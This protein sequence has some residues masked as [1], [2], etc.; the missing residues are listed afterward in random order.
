M[1]IFEREAF[2]R[3]KRERLEHPQIGVG[4]GLLDR[5]VLARNDEIEQSEPFRPQRRF[6]EFDDI[7]PRRGG[8]DREPEAAGARSADQPLDAGAKRTLARPDDFGVMGV[9]AHMKRGDVR[10]GKLGR[11]D[12]AHVG[13]AAH[14]L[15]AAGD[16]VELAVEV[17]VPRPVEAR[18]DEGGVERG[19]VALLRLGQGSVDVENER[20]DHIVPL[21][22]G[23]PSP[24]KGERGKARS[25]KIADRL[26]RIHR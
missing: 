11:R 9:L 14:P 7:D 23:I 6:D 10:V 18:F 25:G 2:V 26:D 22:L 16:A 5:N 24:R 20:F 17:D 19:A 13:V 21:P 1:R 4:R 8:A 3:P 15:L 12:A